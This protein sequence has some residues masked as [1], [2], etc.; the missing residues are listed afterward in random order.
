[1]D[2]ASE[3]LVVEDALCPW[4]TITLLAILTDLRDGDLCLGVLQVVAGLTDVVDGRD[5][6]LVLG[7]PADAVVYLL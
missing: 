1:M 5:A 3:V 7:L 4:P 2:V 6:L